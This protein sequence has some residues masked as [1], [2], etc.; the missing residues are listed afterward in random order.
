MLST[1]V[2]TVSA[3]VVATCI[4]GLI[5]VTYAVYQD[6]N[7]NVDATI[8]SWDEK[9]S[10]MNLQVIVTNKMTDDIKIIK[11]TYKAYGDKARTVLFGTGTVGLFKV[12]ASQTATKS[13]TCQLSNLDSI[14][15]VYIDATID[16]QLGNNPVNHMTISKMFNLFGIRDGTSMGP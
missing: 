13:I 8:K 2:K 6:R 5:G 11:I 10:T 15:K 1:L 12:S 9:T 3:V 16:Y 7:L 4:M 14:K